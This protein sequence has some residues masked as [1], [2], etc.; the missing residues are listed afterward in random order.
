MTSGK[1]GADALLEHAGQRLAIA[2]AH[3]IEVPLDRLRDQ[4]EGE[5]SVGE[6]PRPEGRQH[7]GKRRQRP[8]CS[9]RSFRQRRDFG[10]RLCRHQCGHK[11]GLGREVAIDGTGSDPGSRCNRGDLHCRDT[12]LRRQRARRL[13][14]GLMARSELPLDVLSAAVGHSKE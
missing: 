3:L 1:G 7:S 13:Q 10:L 6:H 12:S 2:D 4:G 5:P 11:F 14:D 8:R 9:V